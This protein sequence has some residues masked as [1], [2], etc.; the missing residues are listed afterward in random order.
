MKILKVNGMRCGH[1]KAAVEEAA[2]K[3]PGVSNPVVDLDAKELRY[4]E[5]A[6]VDEA[7]LRQA[8]F[9]IGF[10][11]QYPHDRHIFFRPRM[12]PFF[13]PLRRNSGY[14]KMSYEIFSDLFQ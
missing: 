10:D 6:P 8:I 7:A 13:C 4:E 1:C 9:D 12:R 2:A 14:Q 11:P 5:S 3:I